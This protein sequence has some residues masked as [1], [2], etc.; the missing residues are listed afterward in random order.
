[1]SDAPLTEDRPAHGSG[2]QHA[3]LVVLAEDH[4]DTRFVYSLI[5]QHYGYR[6]AE[7]S[8]G[9]QAVELVRELRPDLVLMDIGLPVMNGW[10]ASRALKADPQTSNVPL[11]AFSARVDSI[12]DL[13]GSSGNFDGYILKPISPIEL[14]HRVSA[15]LELFQANPTSRSTMAPCEMVPTVRAPAGSTEVMILPWATA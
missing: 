15:Y 8:T 5:L 4:E 9:A 13:A 10:E 6:I 2:R 12:S 14:V 7:A 11:V 3:P 1:M